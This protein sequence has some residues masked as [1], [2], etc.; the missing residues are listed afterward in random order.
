MEEAVGLTILYFPVFIKWVAIMLIYTFVSIFTYGMFVGVTRFKK[1]KQYR[2]FFKIYGPF[3]F[4]FI[5]LVILGS[6]I[7]LV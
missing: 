3:I 2:G 5:S 4:T 6:I 7:Y 1:F